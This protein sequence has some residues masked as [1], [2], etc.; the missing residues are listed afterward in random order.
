MH[1]LLTLTLCVIILAMSIVLNKI[2]HPLYPIIHKLQNTNSYKTTQSRHEKVIQ[3]INNFIHKSKKTYFEYF[4]EVYT[5]EKFNQ[6]LE[7][8]NLTTLFY[9]LLIEIV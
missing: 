3:N 2:H 1:F 7:E 5:R 4:N 9:I 8:Q 6:Y